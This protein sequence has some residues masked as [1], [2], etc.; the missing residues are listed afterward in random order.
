MIYRLNLTHELSCLSV[1]KPLTLPHTKAESY[2]W[3]LVMTII[4]QEWKATSAPCFVM[5]KGTG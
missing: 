1:L 5:A 3:Y 2:V 4:L